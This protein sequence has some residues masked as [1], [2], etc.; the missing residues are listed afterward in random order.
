MSIL[1]SDARQFA[2][3]ST[4]VISRPASPFNNK[5]EFLWVRQDLCV[6]VCVWDSKLQDVC[7]EG[8]GILLLSELD[9]N[10]QHKH[11]KYWLLFNQSYEMYQLLTTALIFLYLL[12]IDC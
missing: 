8:D 7:L 9:K 11:W 1:L 10:M 12:L 5:M 4:N 3:R 2:G 6:C